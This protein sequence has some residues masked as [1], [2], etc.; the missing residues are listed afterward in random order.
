MIRGVCHTGPVRVSYWDGFLCLRC[1][2]C[3]KP[4]LRVAIDKSLL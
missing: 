3:E 4:I 1:W 2:K